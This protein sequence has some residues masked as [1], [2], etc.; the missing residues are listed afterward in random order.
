MA[1]T[2]AEV[3]SAK[4]REKPYKMADSRGLYLLVQTTGGRLWR[5]D[6]RHAG[7]RKTLALG[8]FD[9]VK[10]ADARDLAEDARRKLRAGTDPGVARQKKKSEAARP[11]APARKFENVARRW[12]EART[13]GWVEGYS[14]RVLSRLEDDIFPEFGGRDIA[15]IGAAD[16][17]K[18]LRKIEERGAIETAK[19]VN[20]YVRDVFRYARGEGIAKTDPTADLH[21]ALKT[22]P[23]KKRR[24][25]LK[26]RDL[27]EF[28]RQLEGY[29]G[30][31]RTK[32]A[33]KLALLT[34][35][36]T[37]ELRFARW[38]EFEGLGG[39]EALWRIPADRM[40]MRTEHLVPLTK[41]AAA[42]LERL[43]ALQ[44]E[45]PL[46]FA[47]PTKSGV[48]SEN[49]L[50]FALYRMGYHT[51]ATVHGFRGTASTILNEAGFNRDWIERQLAHVEGN[52]VRASYNSAQWLS[53]RRK[54]MI[55]WADHLDQQRVAPIAETAT[56]SDANNVP[57]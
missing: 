46:V 39:D 31:E 52:E 53:G 10:L 9:A 23:P 54:M 1:L 48:F 40:K 57:S 18:A 13:R 37:S 16:V 17:L 35:V 20:H 42:V 43:N 56:K 8:A 38:A 21:G 3:Q 7:K 28:L 11:T 12:H 26:E 6:Y 33:I 36:R 55:W 50:I 41:Q 34:F 19:R 15:K 14:S 45:G 2:A 22:P 29:D 5:F 4:A 25:A 27:P 32:L 44:F 51:R 49:T 24:A 30:D 47:A